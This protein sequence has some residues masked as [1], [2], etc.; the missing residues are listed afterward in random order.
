MR[1]CLIAFMVSLELGLRDRSFLLASINSSP[2]SFLL[3]H[4]LDTRYLQAVLLLLVSA[5]LGVILRH[6]EVLARQ[7]TRIAQCLFN[8]PREFQLDNCINN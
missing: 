4:L 8:R 7:F 6:L 5:R 3:F 2:S 1:A